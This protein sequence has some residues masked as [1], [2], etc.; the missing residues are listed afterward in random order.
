MLLFANLAFYLLLSALAFYR[1]TALRGCLLA[2]LFCYA[3]AWWRFLALKP[4]TAQ[5]FCKNFCTV[6]LCLTP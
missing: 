6:F 5:S 4:C 1:L 2:Q 3:A